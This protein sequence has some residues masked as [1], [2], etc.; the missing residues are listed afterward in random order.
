SIESVDPGTAIAPEVGEAEQAW[1]TARPSVRRLIEQ[2]RP[3][4]PGRGDAATEARARAE[5]QAAI[6][7]IAKARRQL[8]AV[9]KARYLRAI[10]QRH[11]QLRWLV[12]GWALTLL[13]AAL[14]VA[15]LVRSLLRPIHELG[16]AARRMGEGIP[17]VRA[18]VGGND[19]L[20]LLAERFNEMAAYWEASRQS[21]LTEAAQDSLTG[22]LNRR[23]IL[24]A[25]EA[26]LAAHAREQA[27]LGLFMID[28]DRFKAI[29]DHFGHSAGDRALVW[30]A[31]RLREMLREGDRLGRYGGDEFLVVLPRTTLAQASEIARRIE[32]SFNE[33]AAR[34]AARPGASIGIGAAPEHGWNA[35]SLMEAADRM[36]YAR[37]GQ[38]RT[39]LDAGARPASTTG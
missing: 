31:S 25:L 37:K 32:D 21:L 3:L 23:G 12:A 2:V 28:L 4:H 19:E 5:L 39:D 26:E 7:D 36:L 10:A 27:P 16:R 33:A 30:V 13:V 24:A 20:T 34:E 11:Q 35:A 8:T 9:V 18:A 14:M 1:V 6:D 29:N 17:G 22:V 38:R 15:L